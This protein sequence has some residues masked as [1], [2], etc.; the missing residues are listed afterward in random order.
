MAS[1][2]ARLPLVLI[3]DCP[4]LAAARSNSGGSAT[5]NKTVMNTDQNAHLHGLSSGYAAIGMNTSTEVC[6]ME[7]LAGLSIAITRSFTTSG[8]NTASGT[9]AVGARLGGTT[10]NSSIT[11]NSSV[12]TTTFTQPTFAGNSFDNQPLYLNVRYVMR[13]K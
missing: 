12:V 3:A 1:P 13:V 6:Y 2:L 7:Q 9:E 10:D 11:W 5:F 4:R 8:V